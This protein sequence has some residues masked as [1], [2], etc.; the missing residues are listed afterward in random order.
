MQHDTTH[1]YHPSVNSYVYEDRSDGERIFD[2]ACRCA[3]WIFLYALERSF[4]HD[5]AFRQIKSEVLVSR[6]KVTG[7]KSDNCALG[8]PV[9]RLGS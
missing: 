1:V 4:P 2:K 8:I 3:F 5:E 7:V 6:A 9:P